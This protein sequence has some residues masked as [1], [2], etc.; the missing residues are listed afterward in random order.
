MA[1][2]D[3]G[4]RGDQRGEVLARL[5]RPLESDVGP[6]DSERAQTREIVGVVGRSGVEAIVVDPVRSDDDRHPRRE[7]RVETVR[8]VPADGHESRRAREIWINL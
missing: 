3:R 2:G 6:T 8:R 1:P 4:E 5:D 7:Q